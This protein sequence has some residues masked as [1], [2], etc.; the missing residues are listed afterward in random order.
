MLFRESERLDPRRWILQLIRERRDTPSLPEAFFA[1]VLIFVI[2]FF[3]QLAISANAPAEPSFGFLALSLF[4]SQV[5]C[6]ALPR[7]AD[8]ANPH[9]PPIQNAAPL[10]HADARH[11]CRSRP[12]GRVTASA[13]P[14][15]NRLDSAAVSN[16][17]YAPRQ[18]RPDPA[19]AKVR[20]DTRGCLTFLSRVLPAVCEELAF[21]GFILSG[22]RHSGSKWWAIG[23]AAVFFGIAHG[24]VQQSLSAAILGMVVGY[25]AVQT[26]S[27]IPCMLFH[28]TW[29]TLGFTTESLATPHRTAPDA[30]QPGP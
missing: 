5:V 4:I 2:Q 1:V 20:A 18:A 26:G 7:S 17:R 19:D 27:L 16:Q 22:L 10:A 8:G 15:A 14:A 30:R 12:A 28:V 6:F 21:R 11:V 25:V 9:R 13:R 29:N 23:L 24:I 3:M